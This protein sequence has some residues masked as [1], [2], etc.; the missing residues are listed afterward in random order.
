[1][2]HANMHIHIYYT[3]QYDIMLASVQFERMLLLERRWCMYMYMDMDVY[4][5]LCAHSC[6]EM[7]SCLF[8][9]MSERSMHM[10][11]YVYR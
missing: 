6:N 7:V 3:C 8:E 2:I 4:A 10:D 9:T 11:V 1:M 5:Y